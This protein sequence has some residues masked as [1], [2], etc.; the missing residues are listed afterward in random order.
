MTGKT[1][2]ERARE[3]A[4]AVWMGESSRREIT[5]ASG[6]KPLLQDFSSAGQPGSVAMETGSRV[7]GREREM[8]GEGRVG[9][10]LLK[11]NEQKQSRERD[12]MHHIIWKH[13]QVK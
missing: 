4:R 5:G 10:R 8:L 9:G 13:L 7:R 12:I 11:R 6:G 2:Q 1:K 3:R